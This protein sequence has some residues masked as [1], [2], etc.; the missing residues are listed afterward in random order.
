MGVGNPT[1]AGPLIDSSFTPGQGAPER[2]HM[3]RCR[4]QVCRAETGRQG[5]RGTLSSSTGVSALV[6]I[7]DAIF[8]GFQRQ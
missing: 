2:D 6:S 8:L 1:Q 4:A 7:M 3:L 5:N